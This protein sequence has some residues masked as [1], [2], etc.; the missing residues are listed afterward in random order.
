MASAV[1]DLE[2]VRIAQTCF[3]RNGGLAPVS[4]PLFQ[5]FRLGAGRSVLAMSCMVALLGYRGGPACLDTGIAGRRLWRW[6]CEHRVEITPP[7]VEVPSSLRTTDFALF[8]GSA[9]NPFLCSR[10]RAP[11]SKPFQARLSSCS[12]SHKSPRTVSSILSRS[13][14]MLPVYHTGTLLPQPCRWRTFI[15][16]LKISSAL[17]HCGH[18]SWRWHGIA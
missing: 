9:I 8:A 10:S 13:I 16:P 4:F 7:P 6:S 2:L 17:E 12:V 11:Q 18:W 15:T 14:A 5:A 1:L 3:C